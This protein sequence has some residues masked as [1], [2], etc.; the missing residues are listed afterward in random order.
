MKK[1]IF[2]FF[3]VNAAWFPPSK[4]LFQRAFQTYLTEKCCQKDGPAPFTA[5]WFL[6]MVF[7]YNSFKQGCGSRY[8]GE[9][10]FAFNSSDLDPVI[11]LGRIRPKLP[12]PD[13]GPKSIANHFLNVCIMHIDQCYQIKRKKYSC[14]P[15]F[16]NFYH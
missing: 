13:P 12:D 4:I 11:Q 6:S 8:F 16:V 7:N 10:R 14:F 15:F 9:N 1:Y 2:Q 5:V 3:S